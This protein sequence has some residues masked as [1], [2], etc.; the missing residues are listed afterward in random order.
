[1]HTLPSNTYR[2]S[3]TVV[4][5]AKDPESDYW[6]DQG[7]TLTLEAPSP[8]LAVQKARDHVAQEHP[9]N[10]YTRSF[11]SPQSIHL[12]IPVPLVSATA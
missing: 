7:L 5:E 11:F 6:H 8:Q 3:G 9:E 10:A 12:L 4:T 2:V 1:M